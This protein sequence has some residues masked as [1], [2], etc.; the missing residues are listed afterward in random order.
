MTTN[1][2]NQTMLEQQ[3]NYL[4]LCSIRENYESMAQQAV[5]NQWTHTHYLA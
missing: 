1:K 5:R 2:E 4:K 3:L